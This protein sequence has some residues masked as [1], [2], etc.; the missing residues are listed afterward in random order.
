MRSVVSWGPMTLLRLAL[1]SLL[2]VLAG[3]P[4]GG[5]MLDDTADTGPTDATGGEDATTA[6]DSSGA[7][8]DGSSD[9]A[10][11]TGA[12]PA[13]DAALAFLNAV[14][15]L[16]VAP[17][18]SMTSAGDFPIMAMDIRPADDRTLFSRVDL[19]GEN[20]LRF[21]FT[22]EDHDGTPTL[23]FRNGGYF[24]GLLRDTRT[25]LVE[26]DAAAQ[27]WR[28]C[29]T[30][31]GCEFVDAL[32]TLETPER[33]VLTTMVLGRAHMHWEGVLREDRPLDGEFPYD[34]TPGGDTDPF[35]PMPSL[36]ATL[37]WNMPTTE[38]VDAWLVL[39]TTDC[40]LTP[41]SCQPSRFFRA[42][43]ETGATSVELL[44]DQ[45]HAGEY[46]ANAFLDNNGNVQGTL[47]PDTG[48]RVS[49]PNQDVAIAPAGETEVTIP[50]VFEL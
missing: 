11:S 28:F 37:T 50:L 21:L 13:D 14:P 41:G 6:A 10:D 18:T 35:P 43:A 3:C 26:H 30:A 32:F 23:V 4:G 36:R 33:L 40:N 2:L 19:D 25:T 22:I 48:D 7:G 39:S 15:G 16:W 46:Q 12:P 5:S 47:F 24:L 49:V 20:N 27:T 42:T 38:P 17:V 29:T 9:G 1:P 8:S 44:L 45:V 34:P 31:G